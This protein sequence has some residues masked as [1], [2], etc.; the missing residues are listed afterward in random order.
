[1][2]ITIMDKENINNNLY[3]IIQEEGDYEEF[4]HAGFTCYIERHEYNTQIGALLVYWKGYVKT[5]FRVPPDK[6][7]DIK[8]HNGITYNQD[9]IVGFACAGINDLVTMEKQKYPQ[10]VYRSKE[11]AIDETKRLA[12]QLRKITCQ[13]ILYTTVYNLFK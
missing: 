2:N 12:E 7:D 6:I 9:G 4:Q 13:S 5:G 10:N 3:Q 8:V 11:F 1:M